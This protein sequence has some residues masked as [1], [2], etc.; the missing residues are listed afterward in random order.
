[1]KKSENFA[2][3]GRSSEKSFGIVFFIVFLIVAL[4]PLTKSNEINSW[5]LITSIIF[6]D[7]AFFKPKTLTIL[8]I[9]WNKFGIILG[10]IMAPIVI[11]IVFFVTVVPTG[12]LMK[13]FGKDLLNRKIYKS[14]KTYWIK[15]DKQ[16]GPMKNQF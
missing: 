12:F 11:F 7:L 14:T 1:M 13:I 15:R 3:P 8:N 2:Q 6:L 10:G 9:L 16:L 5:A 4:Y